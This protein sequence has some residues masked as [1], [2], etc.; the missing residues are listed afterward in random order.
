MDAARFDAFTTRLAAPLSRR[1]TAGLLGL[2]SLGCLTAA[3]DAAARKHKKKKKK[4]K[5]GG[6]TS[7]CAA[8]S[9]PC[10]GA[11]IPSSQC[12]TNGD[13]DRCAREVCQA[14]SCGCPAGMTRDSRG[15]CGTRPACVSAGQIVGSA[16]QC[17]SGV[18]IAG[19]VQ[20]S[21]IC[22][23]GHDRCLGD[24]DCAEATGCLGYLCAGPYA[25]AVGSGCHGVCSPPCGADHDCT[26]TGCV[27]CGGPGQPCCSGKVSCGD[28]CVDTASDPRNCGGC[29]KR[30]SI[31][32]TCSGGV[33]VCNRGTG[34]A[35]SEATCCQSSGICSCGTPP[36]YWLDPRTCMPVSS[37]PTG[38]TPCVG[39]R[40]RTCCPSG[41]TCDTSTG[42]CV[43]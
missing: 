25:R 7:G 18:A 11:C 16:A 37:C 27:P 28:V 24:P 39:P 41:S 3:D 34:C 4:G 40:C 5:P 35:N 32:A 22:Q 42:V 33:C 36:F 26:R 1:R 8:G 21:V 38:L 17:C 20:G 23:S 43:Q 15:I 30:C 9:K 6:G 2:L 10:N 19:P 29:G 14:G 13:C 31:N 12:C